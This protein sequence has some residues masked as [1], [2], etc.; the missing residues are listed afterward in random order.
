MASNAVPAPASPCG[1][2]LDP[3]LVA[4]ITEELADYIGPIAEV[5]VKR[6]AKQC[7]TVADLRRA[8]AEEIET[9]AERTQ[10]LNGCRGS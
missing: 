10:F 2:K 6:A 8:V 9:N 4:R 3:E 7:A 1:A 5:V